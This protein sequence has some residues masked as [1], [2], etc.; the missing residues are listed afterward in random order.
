[1]RA[2]I[3]TLILTLHPGLAAQ[4]CGDCDN[5][6]AVDIVDALV[7]SQAAVGLFDPAIWDGTEPIPGACDVAAPFGAMTV[8]DALVIALYLVGIEPTLSCVP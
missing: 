2:L 6:G 8:I 5:S 3:L 7:V 1:M 4:V